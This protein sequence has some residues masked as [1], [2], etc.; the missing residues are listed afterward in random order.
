L[1][2][3]EN[4]GGDEGGLLQVCVIRAL[5]FGMDVREALL[6]WLRRFGVELSGGPAPVGPVLGA[7]PDR[8]WTRARGGV[9]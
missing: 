1:R 7:G 6:D 4:L 2:G 5:C 9:G 8:G 3:L